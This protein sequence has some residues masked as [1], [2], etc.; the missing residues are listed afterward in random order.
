MH[1]SVFIY[2]NIIRSFRSVYNGQEFGQ[3]GSSKQAV[4]QPLSEPKGIEVDVDD[5]SPD[6]LESGSIS[7]CHVLPTTTIL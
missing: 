5:Q 4:K 3:P 7:G 6:S 1:F 2:I